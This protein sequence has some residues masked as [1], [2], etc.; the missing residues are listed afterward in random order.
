MLPMFCI[1]MFQ[2]SGIDIL[3]SLHE[4]YQGEISLRELIKRLKRDL[5]TIERRHINHYR[6]RIANNRGLIQY[7]LNLMSP[8]FTIVGGI[9]ETKRWVK[10]FLDKVFSLHP[11]VFIVDFSQ[12]TGKSFMTLQNMIA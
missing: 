9:P 10:S 11:H 3:N 5:P 8:E 7:G 4:L 1:P 6:K 2:Y 12:T